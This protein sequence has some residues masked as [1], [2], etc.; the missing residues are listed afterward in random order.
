MVFAVAACG[1]CSH[2][3]TTTSALSNVERVDNT[4]ETRK[5]V[6]ED[7]DGFS[8]TDG[9]VIVLNPVSDSACNLQCAVGWYHPQHGNKAPFSCAPETKDRT[10]SDGIPLYPVSCSSAFVAHIM[11]FADDV[12]DSKFTILR[13][14]GTPSD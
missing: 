1:C 9:D 12:R 10:S 8:V 14:I 3:T 4:C 6:L 11:I 13:C 5:I 7:D 2:D